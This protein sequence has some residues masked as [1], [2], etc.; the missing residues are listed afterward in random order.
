MTGAQRLEV[1][2]V[3]TMFQKA[4]RREEKNRCRIENT[5]NDVGEGLTGVECEKVG[6]VPYSAGRSTSQS[7]PRNV[8]TRKVEGRGKS[9]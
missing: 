9:V 2:A 7:L 8:Y 4:H 5:S 3:G 1:L 6:S